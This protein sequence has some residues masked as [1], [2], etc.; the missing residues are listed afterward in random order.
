MSTPVHR[1]TPRSNS[2]LVTLL[3]GIGAIATWVIRHH[4]F[5]L[6][7]GL[8]MLVFSALPFLVRPSLIGTVL[9]HGQQQVDLARIGP[10]RLVGTA[11]MVALQIAD[12]GLSKPIT[13]PVAVNGRMT[14][15]PGDVAALTTALR[16]S[17][18]NA[19][20]ADEIDS[21]EPLSRAMRRQRGAALP[22]LRP[23]A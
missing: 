19:L 11:R 13:L 12:P 6:V 20:L 2:H 15:R 7:M 8:L 16:S 9:R 21:Y 4:T 14:Y 23:Q 10:A 3:C 5:T 17:G 1:F 18:T 22:S